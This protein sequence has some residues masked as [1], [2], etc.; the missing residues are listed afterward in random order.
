MA[1]KKDS[2]ATNEGDEV[3]NYQPGT[4]NFP[5]LGTCGCVHGDTWILKK[6]TG[7]GT[8]K[9][10]PDENGFLPHLAIYP[11]TSYLKDPREVP[12]KPGYSFTNDK[13]PPVLRVDLASVYMRWAG[14][15]Q[16]EGG[17][18]AGGA[19]PDP[20]TIISY[21]FYWDRQWVLNEAEGSVRRYMMAP[22]GFIRHTFTMYNVGGTD[23]AS[24]T[25]IY[26]ERPM[27][28]SR[29]WTPDAVPITASFGTGGATTAV[30]NSDFAQP[31]PI[32]PFTHLSTPAKVG[33]LVFELDL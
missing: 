24:G 5:A 14:S 30:L 32:G 13:F 28:A 26:L 12:V 1:I 4:Q 10:V 15:V 8:K 6:I 11:A 25:P 31:V 22:V 9:V 2:G 23:P 27:C 19:P 3:W 20:S 21:T 33:V 17:M 18:I 7:P 16:V 29:V